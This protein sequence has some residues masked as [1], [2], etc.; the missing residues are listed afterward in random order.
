MEKMGKK[1]EILPLLPFVSLQGIASQVFRPSVSLNKV[2]RVPKFG[3]IEIRGGYNV[4]VNGKMEIQAECTI[5]RLGRSPF[6]LTG[7]NYACSYNS[8]HDLHRSAMRTLLGI[9]IGETFKKEANYM[10]YRV[11]MSE[12]LQQYS[13]DDEK[14]RKDFAGRFPVLY[15]AVPVRY[16]AI[17][18]Q[19][20]LLLNSAHTIRTR[21]EEEGGDPDEGQFGENWNFSVDDYG[22]LD[23]GMMREFWLF[24]LSENPDIAGEHRNEPMQ[25]YE[26]DV[27][28]LLSEKIEVSPD[29]LARIDGRAAKKP[30]F[31]LYG[32]KVEYT[33]EKQRGFLHKKPKWAKQQE[34]RIVFTCVDFHE[35][36]HMHPVLTSDKL[37][38]HMPP[39]AF[40]K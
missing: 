34:V 32:G 25:T 10:L 12:E 30:S 40:Q 35:G 23:F 7:M 27:A 15:H 11:G 3:T 5:R 20:K 39:S 13:L 4:F 28:K 9:A 29:N 18:Q 24:C 6:K 33:E 2:V 31:A 21:E 37:E 26:V 22:N 19:G 8:A 16:E 36:Q 14:K 38:V 1:V 17:F